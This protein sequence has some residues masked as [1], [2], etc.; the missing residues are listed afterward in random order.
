MKD[1]VIVESPL[2]AKKIQKILGT[3]YYVLSSF[4]HLRNLKPKNMGIK[5]DENFK[6]MFEIDKKKS[7]I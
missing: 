7:S 2:K 1:L 4:G 6:P 3:G 5:I